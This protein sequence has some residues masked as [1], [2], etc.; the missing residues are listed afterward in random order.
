M[1][2]VPQ[3]TIPLD[4]TE[5]AKKVLRLIDDEPPP[6]AQEGPGEQPSP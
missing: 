6:A 2:D 1:F 3:T 4:S 5:S